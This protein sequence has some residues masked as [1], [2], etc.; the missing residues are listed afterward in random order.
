MWLVLLLSSA[1]CGPAWAVVQ[2]STPNPLFRQKTLG[3]EAVHFEG[4][5]IGEKAEREWLGGK[6]AGQQASF[7]E[8]KERF[9]KSF[10][11][12]LAEDLPE[13]T[14]VASPGPSPLFVRPHV[15]R[16]EPGF[17]GG[18]TAKPT[19]VEMKVEVLSVDG[20]VFDVVEM[21]AS[22]PATTT[23]P[24]TGV[25]LRAAA[26]ILGGQVAEFLRSRVGLE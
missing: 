20:E 1:A 11:E 21:R 18:A 10:A 2:L 19:E 12:Q 9:A 4:V 13:V 3:V 14:L 16:I 15:T 25:R 17:Y 8:D 22:V 5:R 6:D 26:E 7:A 23:S 24:E